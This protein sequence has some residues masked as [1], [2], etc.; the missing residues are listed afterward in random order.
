MA[1][2]ASLR[3]ESRSESP[4]RSESAQPV[5]AC[6]SPVGASAEVSV[7]DVGSPARC[8]SLADGG[9]A[10]ESPCPGCGPTTPNPY[11]WSRSDSQTAALVAAG[12]HLLVHALLEGHARPD[13]RDPDVLVLG[14]FTAELS[15][16]GEDP[17][18]RLARPGSGCSCRRPLPHRAVHELLRASEALSK[19]LSHRHEA[20]VAFQCAPTQPTQKG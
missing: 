7:G 16:L 18:E 4:Q 13:A 8:A 20:R 3:A 10:P 12:G 17:L 9:S 15:L 14:S 6:C 2:K 19:Y 5:A 1:K 11:T